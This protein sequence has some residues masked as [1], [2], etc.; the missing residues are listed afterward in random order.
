MLLR[1]GSSEMRGPQPLAEFS[2]FRFRLLF[3]SFVGPHCQAAVNDE[4]FANQGN[5]G[6]FVAVFG[7]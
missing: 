6:I 2:Q 7:S 4:T 1:P 3:L 5:W